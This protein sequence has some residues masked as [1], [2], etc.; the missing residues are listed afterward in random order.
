MKERLRKRLKKI[1]YIVKELLLFVIIIVI[2]EIVA[3]IFHRINR[4]NY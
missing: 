4:N 2:I 3:I 1:R